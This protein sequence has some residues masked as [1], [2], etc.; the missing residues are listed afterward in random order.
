MKPI[1]I[2]PGSFSPPTYGHVE[3]AKRAAK[4]FKEI[5]VICSVNP[6]KNIEF[7]P[8]E[9][10]RLWQTYDLC[11]QIKVETFDNF[12]KKNGE[13]YQFVM[14]R[15]IRDDRDLEYEKGVVLF[16]WKEF[17]ITNYLYIVSD[18]TFKHISSTSARK[19]AENLNLLELG[20]Q[21]SPLTVTSMLEKTLGIKNLYMV[22]G[23]PGAGKSTFLKMLSQENPKNVF[24]DTDELTD[25][26]KPML[27]QAFGKIDSVDL[28]VEHS[29][30]LKE[31]IGP[32]WLELVR[33]SLRAV[34]RDSNVFLEIPYGFQEDKMAFRFFGGKI[35]Y[36][37][38]KNKKQ[39]EQ[40]IIGRGTPQIVKFIGK[41]PGK[42]E[43]MKIA[44]RHKLSVVYVDTSGTLKDLKKEVIRVD[45]LIQKKEEAYV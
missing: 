9:C 17:G 40:R 16:N 32:A 22:V 5:H 44:K 39:N 12:K 19:L 33:K 28:A 3:I 29:E 27:E 10:K 24:I 8:E 31:V 43:T 21:I 25:Q 6:D 36:V 41:I 37:G 1:Y 11:P 35:I 26:L 7:T 34:P 4:L 18:D 38:C 14:I 45:Q 15:G 42:K 23:K 13:K 30:K 20:T 2:Y